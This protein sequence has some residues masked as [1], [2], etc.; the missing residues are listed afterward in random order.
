[1]IG[2]IKGLFVA[3]FLIIALT[4]LLLI[5]GLTPHTSALA[6][7]PVAFDGDSYIPG[8][9]AVFH[10]QDGELATAETCTGTW[11]AL[12]ALVTRETPW[13]VVNGEPQP[14][15]YQGLNSGCSYDKETTANTPL[16][17]PPTS[18]LPWL[19]LVN[20]VRVAMAGVDFVTGEF[21]LSSKV[22]ASSTVALPFY[23][24]VADTYAASEQRA[25]VTSTAD[26]DGEWIAIREVK[27][28]AEASP[29]PTSGLFRG[30]VLLYTNE[31]ASNPGDGVV[32]VR[33]DGDTLTVTYFDANGQVIAS[34]TIDVEAITPI[35]A[36]S[37]LALVLMAGLFALV[38][39]WRLRRSRPTLGGG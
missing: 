31:T 10:I 30:E 8:N 19:A 9:T 13:N 23:F 34:D 24:D 7:G 16:R 25:K 36:T 39:A 28:E 33:H 18:E 37:T 1:M 17:L 6:D 20:N 2:T 32:R 27:S 14:E 15:V 35:P 12:T 5:Q 26:P 4:L 29:D 21:R 3:A 38:I 11:G 22:N